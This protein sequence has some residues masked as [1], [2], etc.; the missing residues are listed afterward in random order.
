MGVLYWVQ[1]APGEKKSV[2]G[3]WNPIQ[4][5]LGLVSFKMIHPRGAWPEPAE[6]LSGWPG[7]TRIDDGVCKWQVAAACASVFHN[8]LPQHFLTFVYSNGGRGGFEY[9]LFSAGVCG[10]RRI[11][12]GVAMSVPVP[13]S[14]AVRYLLHYRTARHDTPL[15]PMIL[16]RSNSVCPPVYN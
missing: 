3:C 11:A 7:R 5:T 10:A 13:L 8:L 12:A 15:H 6:P 4:V 14:A 16:S 2:I 9:G 1:H